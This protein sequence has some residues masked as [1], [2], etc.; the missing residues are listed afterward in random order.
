MS[1]FKIHSRKEPRPQYKWRLMT[2][3][4]EETF[5]ALGL[6]F[7]LLACHENQECADGSIPV[8]LC[9][10]RHPQSGKG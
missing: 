4:V 8:L 9:F 10:W 3:Q 7:H 1:R 6:F 5:E 2:A